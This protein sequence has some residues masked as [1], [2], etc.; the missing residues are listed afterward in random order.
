MG[1]HARPDLAKFTVKLPKH[2]VKQLD[3]IAA[4]EGR[5][6]S[7]LLADGADLYVKIYGRAPS[8]GLRESVIELKPG[9]GPIGLPPDETELPAKKKTKGKKPRKRKD[10]R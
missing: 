10:S 7:D 2:L 8:L 3:A 1:R 5:S 6:R 9:Y 4:S